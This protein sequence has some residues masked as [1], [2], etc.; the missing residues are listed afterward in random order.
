[1]LEALGPVAVHLGRQELA[2]SLAPFIAAI[3][4]PLPGPDR[5]VVWEAVITFCKRFYGA[6]RCGDALPVAQ[7]V[8][9]QASVAGDVVLERRAATVCGLL[10]GDMIDVVTAV[11]YQLR[12]L[13]LAQAAGTLRDT[14]LIW[15]NIGL[16]FSAAGNGMLAIQCYRRALATVEGEPN[17]HSIRR[18]AGSNLANMLHNRGDYEEGLRYGTLAQRA[19]QQAD[20]VTDP[21]GTILL[22]RNL[23]RLLV[24]MGRLDEAKHLVDE[25]ADMAS[26]LT[27]PRSLIAA[28][29]A[30]G[31]YELAVGGTD[32]ALTRLEG[33]LAQAR[34]VTGA[35]HDA[36]ASVARAEEAAGHPERALLRLQELSDWVYRNAIDR[37]RDHVELAGVFEG[38]GGGM[39]PQQEQARARLQGRLRPPGEPDEWKAY[40]RLGVAAALRMD[41][42]GWHGIRVGALTKALALASGL[43]PLQ[44]LEIGLAAELHDI[45]L[46]SVP[47]AILAKKGELNEVERAMVERHTD[48]GAEI[49]QNDEHSRILLAREIA[50]YHHARWDGGGYPPRVG[51]RFIP[52]PARICAVADAYDCMV[53]G[54]DHRPPMSMSEALDELRREAGRQFD[55]ELVECFEAVIRDEA[56]DLGVDPGAVA[57]LESFQEIVISLHEDRGFI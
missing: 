36:L 45:G 14:A 43:P 42:T 19:E 39:D 54:L 53:C 48:A 17:A 57:G 11:S 51:G 52:L 35:L 16:A 9:D 12:A 8:L 30:R 25:V 20:A 32:I 22:R 34:S 28:T 7:A 13:K 4:E 6:G 1:V 55:P 21:L 2:E 47:E 33:A 41:S 46:I 15:N 37:A 3:R 24:A 10:A 5:A 27:E 40:Q 18:T 31:T 38:V 50:K 49:L 44:A 56:A 26:R 23:I 29:I